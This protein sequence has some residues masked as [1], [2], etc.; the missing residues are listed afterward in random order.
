[1]DLQTKVSNT[2][3]DNTKRQQGAVNGYTPTNMPQT[4]MDLEATNATPSLVIR[5]SDDGD[6]D[7]GT[8][9]VPDDTPQVTMRQK[10]LQRILANREAARA[11]YLRRK[12]MISELQATVRDQSSRST[13]IEA[14]NSQLRDE[15]RELREMIAH[16]LSRRSLHQGS[17]FTRPSM[18]LYPVM[19]AMCSEDSLLGHVAASQSLPIASP[20]EMSLLSWRLQVGLLNGSPSRRLGGFTDY[21]VQQELKSAANA[22]RDYLRS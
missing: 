5:I 18:E 7:N 2:Q 20:A 11:S 6:D 15:I 14:E 17:A 13:A 4:S 21:L 19:G 9:D 10:K 8:F 16:L 1:M 3:D 12:K 22:G